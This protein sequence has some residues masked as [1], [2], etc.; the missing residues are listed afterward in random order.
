MCRLRSGGKSLHLAEKFPESAIISRDVSAA[1]VKLIE[2]NVKRMGYVNVTYQVFNAMKIDEAMSGKADIVVADL[3]CSGLGVIGNK[4]DI[5][6]RLRIDDLESLAKLQKDI[7]AS[8]QTMVSESGL[9]CFSTCTLNKGE[10]SVEET[11][12]KTFIL[13]LDGN[14]MT[15]S[16]SSDS[17]TGYLKGFWER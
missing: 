16:F 10:I 4:P 11:G 12:G 7:L 15:S 17:S 6:H 8:V 5:K 14:Q 3:P 9:L 1:K 2:E 13:K